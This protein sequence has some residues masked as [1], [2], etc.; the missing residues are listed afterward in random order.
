VEDGVLPA[1]EGLQHGEGGCAGVGCRGRG[2]R[3]SVA[4]PPDNPPSSTVTRPVSPVRRTSIR[5]E[6]ASHR[7]RSTCGSAA[8]LSCPVHTP[9]CQAADGWGSYLDDDT[10]VG[11]HPLAQIAES[12]TSA[13]LPSGSRLL[14]VPTAKRIPDADPAGSRR[15]D[16]VA[17]CRS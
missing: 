8:S 3:D 10:P 1:D 15:C 11:G 14:D 4:A 13:K 5:Q 12:D 2:H 9:H 6:W 16:G 17:C 7:C